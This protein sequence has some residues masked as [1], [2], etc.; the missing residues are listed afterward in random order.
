M[1]NT[2]VEYNELHLLLLGF[3]V[4]IM[5]YTCYYFFLSTIA[6]CNTLLCMTTGSDGS[7]EEKKSWNYTASDVGSWSKL[8]LVNQ[9]PPPIRMD[10]SESAEAVSIPDSEHGSIGTLEGAAQPVSSTARL[11]TRPPSV[12]QDYLIRKSAPYDSRSDLL[13]L[14]LFIAYP[15]GYSAAAL[16]FCV[17]HEC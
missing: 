13:I 8:S 10:S 2:Y 5:S 6:S 17:G 7:Q 3:C 12:E 15:V 16:A 11:L 14:V 4:V 9:T 1:S